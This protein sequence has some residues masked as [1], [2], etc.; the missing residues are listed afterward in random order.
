MFAA[1]SAVLSERYNFKG[2]MT[3]ESSELEHDSL[4]S[5]LN[6]NSSYNKLYQSDRV[7]L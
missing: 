4:C 6:G 2:V 5:V 1:Q 3:P 7:F